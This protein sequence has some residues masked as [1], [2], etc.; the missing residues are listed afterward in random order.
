MGLSKAMISI[1]VPCYNESAVFDR[2]RLALAGLCDSLSEK[3]ATE[4][5]F[6]DDGSRDDTWQ[7]ITAFAAADARVR[8]VMLSRNFGHQFALTCGYDLARGD[9]IVSLDADLQDPPEIVPRL[10]EKW[11]EGFDVVL[12]VR[13]RR[14]GDGWFKRA[15]ASAFYRLIRAIGGAQ[16]RADSG[17]FRLMSRAALTALNSLREQHRFIRGMVGWVGFRT[18]EIVYDRQPRSAGQTKYSLAKMVRLA[19]DAI[20]SFSSFPLR[21]AYWTALLLMLG[22]FG[23][24]V[25]VI[26]IHFVYKVPLVPGWSSLLVA[27]VAFGTMNLVCLGLIG[28]YI[29]RIYEQGKQR[30][31]YLVKDTVGKRDPATAPSQPPTGERS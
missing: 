7:K 29:G 3:F 18:A 4:L 24:L 22:S 13:R 5:I 23:Y 14:E 15:S 6:I 9:A 28:E 25:R 2:A 19:V 21:V 20:I 16:V 26:V 30:P 27:I 31:L 1:V 10:V 8:G 11:Q 12:A 17:D